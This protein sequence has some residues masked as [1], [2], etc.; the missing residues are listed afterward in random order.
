MRERHK[1]MENKDCNVTWTLL[2]ASCT[3]W[4]FKGH[5][6]TEVWGEY[7]VYNTASPVS[8]GR[9]HLAGGGYECIRKRCDD[10]KHSLAIHRTSSRPA[11]SSTKLC[12]PTS[13]IQ[14]QPP[15]DCLT[16][17]L[18]FILTF[19]LSL[20]AVAGPIRFFISAAIVTNACSTLVALFALVSRNGMRSWS[21]Y[22]YNEHQWKLSRLCIKLRYLCSSIIFSN[23]FPNV[24]TCCSNHQMFSQHNLN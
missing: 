16:G 15:P 1:L 11:Q 5:D 23:V 2:S 10:T 8:I 3:V 12:P 4:N 21:A 17:V 18:A 13:N 22:S 24:F 19:G 7:V 20:E 6:I 14:Q 9:Q